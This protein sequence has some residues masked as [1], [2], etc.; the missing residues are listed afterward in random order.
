MLHISGIELIYQSLEEVKIS[1]D[2]LIDE[3]TFYEYQ[4]VVLVDSKYFEAN[5]LIFI[6]NLTVKDDFIHIT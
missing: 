1:L 2:S 5:F 3:Q 6:E 4:G